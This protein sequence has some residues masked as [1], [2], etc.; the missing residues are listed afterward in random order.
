MRTTKR[1]RLTLV[2]GTLAALVADGLLLLGVFGARS[3]DSASAWGIAPMALYII[4]LICLPAFWLAYSLA[5]AALRARSE[6]VDFPRWPAL[7]VAFLVYGIVSVLVWHLL[8]GGEFAVV[9]VG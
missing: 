8:G 4:V 1:G 3:A 5:T 9:G 6:S 7:L 2:G